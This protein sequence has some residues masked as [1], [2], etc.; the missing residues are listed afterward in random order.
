MTEKSENIEMHASA[1]A[2]GEDTALISLRE[3][4]FA[5]YDLKNLDIKL[6]PYEIDSL[7]KYLDK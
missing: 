7:T 2:H 6:N 3:F 4:K 5:L 1:Y